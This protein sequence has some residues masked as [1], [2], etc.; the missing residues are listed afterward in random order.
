MQAFKKNPGFYAGLIAV[1]L[2]FIAGCVMAVFGL[3]DKNT[4]DLRL[5]QAISTSQVLLAGHVF[6][7]SAE[8]V[9]LTPANVE[10][11]RK[12]LEGL[13]LQED[14]LRDLIAG[15]DEF[16]LLG[17]A[18]SSASELNSLIKQSV[19]E[20]KRFAIDHD[21]RMMPNEQCDFGFRRYIRNPGISP[22]K[23]FQRV[24]QQRRIIDDLYRQ[25][26]DSRPTGAPLMLLAIDREPVETYA[27]IPKGKPNAGTFGPEV[28]GARNESDEFVPSRT[29]RRAG[30]VDSMAFRVR[31]VGTTPTLR[32]FV[33][34]LRN[35]G[36]PYAVASVD[37]VPASAEAAKA[38]A[39]VSV[40]PVATQAPG[41]GGI[42][43]P[44]FIVADEAAN[45]IK[46]NGSAPAKD[47]RQTIVKEVPSEF[48]VQVE[49]LSVISREKASAEGEPKK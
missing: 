2:L 4:T 25:L 30:L 35:S 11:A 36:R 7:P 48:T 20:W 29:F 37:V 9:S 17:K 47:E 42:A 32:T 21:I 15:K 16:A 34:K 40:V 6:A 43:L 44:G 19:D 26:I 41:A 8:A 49:Y 22:K 10:S 39:T 45:A 18:S 1:G 28:E 23:E 33:N 46:T 12:D 38:L 13:R 5:R 24:D 31:F 27:L 14:A 3:L